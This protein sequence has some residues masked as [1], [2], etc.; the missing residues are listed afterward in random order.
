MIG[1]VPVSKNRTHKCFAGLTCNNGGDAH[2]L[3]RES[4]NDAFGSAI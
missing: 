4:V 2:R 1:P 3:E